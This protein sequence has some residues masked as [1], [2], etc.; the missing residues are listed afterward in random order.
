[1]RELTGYPEIQE[2]PRRQQWQ[3]L[4]AGI[5]WGEGTVHLWPERTQNLGIFWP[6]KAARMV[7]EMC[8][9]MDSPFGYANLYKRITEI[10]EETDKIC[11]TQ[12]HMRAREG[13]AP[14]ST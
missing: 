10:D 3:K 12:R 11:T 8:G 13:L 7:L 14:Y 5:E 6:P 9:A 1:M 4:V 2:V